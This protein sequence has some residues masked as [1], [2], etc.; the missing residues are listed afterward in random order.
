MGTAGLYFLPP[1]TTMNGEKYLNLLKSKLE[2][3]MTVHN[4]QIFM[5][6]GVPCHRSKLVKKFLE[7]KSIQM[8]EWPENSP[9]L[10]PIENLW[11]I[12]K[13]KVSEKHP[14]TRCAI[15]S[16]IKEVW[17]KEISLDYC[18]KLIESMP[19]CLQEVIKNK[20]GHTKYRFLVFFFQ[21]CVSLS[22]F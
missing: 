5:H 8:L 22:S 11:S 13:K 9:D 12:M 2:L 7:E 19:H 17:V 15:Q 21:F 1:G 18:C 3:Y 14:T 16:A 20:G 10:N 6:D 4:F